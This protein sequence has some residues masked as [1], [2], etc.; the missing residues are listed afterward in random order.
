MKSSGLP[1]V[2]W[3]RGRLATAWAVVV[4]L[5]LYAPL[6]M[7]LLQSFNSARYGTKWHGF[8]TQWYRNLPANESVWEACVNSLWLAGSSTLVAT[9]LGTALAYGL[10]RHWFPGS[11]TV[12]RLLPLTVFIPD[13]LL[14]VAL[15][16]VVGLLQQVHAVLGPGMTAMLIGHVTFQLP[17]VAL[18]VRARMATLDPALE[19]AAM[20]LGATRWQTFRHVTLP[21]LQ[22]GIGA[23]ALLAFTLSL[24]DFIVSFCT[25]GPGATTLPIWI[26]ASAKRGLSP[27]VHALS[28]VLVM[29]AVA[30][31]VA[32]RLVQKKPWFST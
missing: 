10:S 19:E 9:A 31:T 22:P 24:D 6:A 29:A 2:S 11:D 25:T 18:V 15:L 20:D 26:Y 16:L 32:L 17:L 7:I 5:F 8:T 27:E 28:S 30:L 21:L 23:A 3:F 4:Y 1:N 12:L 14:G 13:I